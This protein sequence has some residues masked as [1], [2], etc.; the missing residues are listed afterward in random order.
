MTR[1][2]LCVRIVSRPVKSWR[3]IKQHPFMMAWF[4]QDQSRM[5]R[6][7]ASFCELDRG[8]GPACAVATRAPGLQSALWTAPIC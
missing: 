1:Q 8:V 4:A 3:A 6:R 7:R 2:C 5:R